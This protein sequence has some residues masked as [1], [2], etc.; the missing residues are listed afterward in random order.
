MT[1]TIRDDSPRDVASPIELE[2][3]SGKG[4]AMRGQG[5]NAGSESKSSF[6]VI[7]LEN[8]TSRSRMTAAIPFAAGI[9][10]HILA[11]EMTLY[12]VVQ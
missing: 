2:W 3:G 7:T 1:E 4:Q 5:S 9:T 10:K 11:T 8:G 6:I 12:G